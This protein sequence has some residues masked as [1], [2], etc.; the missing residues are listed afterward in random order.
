MNVMFP[1]LMSSYGCVFISP[2]SQKLTS[3]LL[4]WKT[5]KTLDLINQEKNILPLWVIHMTSS[6]RGVG[7][8]KAKL[9][10]YWK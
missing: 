4:H 9:R 6:L 8:G 1:F 7:V 5:K 2:I 3:R 10:C